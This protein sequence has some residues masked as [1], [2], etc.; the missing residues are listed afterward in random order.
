MLPNISMY[1]FRYYKTMN[2]ID[3]CK[4][5]LRYAKFMQSSNVQ[6]FLF[7]KFRTWV[8]LSYRRASVPPT[9]FHH[10]VRIVS[11]RTRE[12]MVGVNTNRII[13]V[14]T[15]LMTLF[16]VSVFKI[17]RNTMGI[18]PN[19]LTANTK[20]N[21]TVPCFSFLTLPHPTTV[22]REDDSIKFFYQ[23]RMHKTI[24]PQR[25]VVHQYSN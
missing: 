21:H 23:L 25:L 18:V 12:K 9:F 13:A 8:T 11:L 17:K 7:G 16:D 14:M 6:D 24:I 22:H 10:V 15:R 20:R 3:S 2:R 1:N 5:M 19:A 4:F